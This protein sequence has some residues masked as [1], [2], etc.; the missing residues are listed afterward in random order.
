MFKKLKMKKG[1]SMLERKASNNCTK[2]EL[3]QKKKKEK[4]RAELR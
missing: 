4:G 1:K 2:K 3:K